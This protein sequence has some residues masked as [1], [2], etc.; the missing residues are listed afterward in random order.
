MSKPMEFHLKLRAKAK[1]AASAVKDPTLKFIAYHSIL[2]HLYELPR[3]RKRT[4]AKP[5]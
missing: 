3:K 5:S 4:A 2:R 1:R